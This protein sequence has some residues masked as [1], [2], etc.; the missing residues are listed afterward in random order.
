M[1]SEA[2]FG[3]KKGLREDELG[4]EEE[5]IVAEGEENEDEADFF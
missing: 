1:K 4:F 3:F 5:E 2:F